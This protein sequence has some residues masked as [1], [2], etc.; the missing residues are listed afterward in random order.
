M[1]MIVA[2]KLCV[3]SVPVLSL[4]ACL[5]LCQSCLGVSNKNFAKIPLG[6][7]A[8]E[9]TRLI[10]KPDAVEVSKKQSFPDPGTY[11]GPKPSRILFDLPEG[12][13]IETWTY[14]GWWER[15][16]VVFQ[17]EDDRKTVVSTGYHHD[18]MVY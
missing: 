1:K 14:N 10:G 12:T 16:W 6:M 18:A 3:R 15:W 5:L 7:T 17:I 13:P 8:E 4:I 2:R 9:V 11:F